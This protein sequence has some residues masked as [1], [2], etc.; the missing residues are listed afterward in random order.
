MSSMAITSNRFYYCPLIVFECPIYPIIDPMYWSV[1]YI[2]LSTQCTGVSYISYYRPS[3][4]ECPIYPIIDPVYWIVHCIPP[5][6][7][8]EWLNY[9]SIIQV[10]ISGRILRIK[11]IKQIVLEKT[12]WSTRCD[13]WKMFVLP[14]NTVCFMW[15]TC[16]I[17]LSSSMTLDKALLWF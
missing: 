16:G 6:Q 15:I 9:L 14:W 4:L 2:L 13:C 1:L 17:M 7:G 8:S 10:Q 12:F 11:L 5:L 3:V